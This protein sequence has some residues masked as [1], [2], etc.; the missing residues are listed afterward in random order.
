MEGGGKSVCVRRGFFRVEGSR[1]TPDQCGLFP[2]K[3][4]KEKKFNE[5]PGEGSG[6]MM[7]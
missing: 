3:K 1:R 4:K 7:R 5:E 6:E 2:W